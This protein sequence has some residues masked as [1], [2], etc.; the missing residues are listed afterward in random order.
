MEKVGTLAGKSHPMPQDRPTGRTSPYRDRAIFSDLDQNLIGDPPAMARFAEVLR[1]NRRCVSFGIVTGR[2]IDSALA[3]IKKHRIPTP[4]VL[5]T[6]LGT[7]IHY[8][9]DLTEDDYWAEHID[10]HWNRQQV[11]RVLDKLPGLVLQPKPQQSAFKLSYYIDPQAAP[12]VDEIVALIRQRDLT[13]NVVSSFGQFLDVIPARA[14]KGQALRYVSQRLDIP[15]EHIL[16]AG[17]SGADEDM[18]RGNTLAVVV[19]NRHHEELS[20]L[21]DQERI[22]FAGQ[23]HAAGILEAIRHYDFFRSCQVPQN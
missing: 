14:S 10:H 5:I 19:A 9:Q 17:G 20:Q 16:A 15:L 12:S 11:R 4:D 8:R 1:N 13:A 6:S 23:P 21:V 22:Y 18:M 2:R 7:R 3:L